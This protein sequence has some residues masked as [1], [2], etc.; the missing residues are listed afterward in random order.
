MQYKVLLAL[1][2]CLVVIPVF[3]QPA[4]KPPEEPKAQ[5][6]Q[7]TDSKL[8]DPTSMDEAKALFMEAWELEQQ[9]KYEE[10]FARYSI[11][12]SYFQKYAGKEESIYHGCFEQHEWNFGEPRKISRSHC[13]L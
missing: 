4:E 11:V 12:L 2:L 13:K 7:A 1:L 5:P 9:Q 8:K 6:A 10:A 3:S